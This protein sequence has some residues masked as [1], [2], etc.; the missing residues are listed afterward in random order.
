M[1]AQ[2]DVSLA[3]N[4]TALVGGLRG[5]VKNLINGVRYSDVVIV[6]EFQIKNIPAAWLACKVFRKPLIVDGFVGRYETYVGDWRHVG[7][8]SPKAMVYRVMDALAFHLSDLY[9]IDTEVRAQQIRSKFGVRDTHAA[10]VLSLPVGAPSWAV[11]ITRQVRNAGSPYR[12]LYYGNYVPLHG[13]EHVIDAVKRISPGLAVQLTMVGN[14]DRRPIAEQ[15]VSDL[16]LGDIVKF[17]DSVPESQLHSL[18]EAHD[19]VLGIFGS[20]AKASSV[21]ANKVWQG[22]ACGRPVLTRSSDALREISEIAGD[23]LVQVPSADSQSIGQAVLELASETDSRIY[24]GD[25]VSVRLEQYVA[26]KY[27]HF[28]KAIAQLVHT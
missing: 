12:V 24:A 26:A 16:E 2:V 14:G 18:I 3:S 15:R 23:L 10:R 5:G 21:I 25:Y 20:S 27:D 6:S 7:E 4:K 22:L 19:L 17:V 13:V 8:T 28:G 1:A 9:L 11:P